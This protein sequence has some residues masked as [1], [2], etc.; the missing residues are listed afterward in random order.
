MTKPRLNASASAGASAALFLDFDGVLH[1]SHCSPGDFLCH[2]PRLLEALG[3]ANVDIVICSSW[4]F[5]RSFEELRALFSP[6]IQRNI[7]GVTGAAFIGRHARWYEIQSY[8]KAH[9]ITNWRVLDDSRWEF[10]DRCTELI[11]CDGS[12]GMG[13]RQ[14]DQIRRWL[15]INE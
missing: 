7:V 9:R 2:L 3:Q 8:V 15:G 10:P 4:R 6:D 12:R 13:Q 1:P 5:Q 14:V 11:A